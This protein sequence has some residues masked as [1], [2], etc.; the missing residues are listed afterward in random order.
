MREQIKVTSVVGKRLDGDVAYL[1]LKQFQEGTHRRAAPTIGAAPRGIATRR[2]PAC[3]LDMRNNPG[4]LVD[5]AE[6]VADEF[7]DVG[8]DLL[9]AAPRRGG[10]RGQGARRAARSRR[11]R[12]WCS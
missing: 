5:E 8:D 2:S 7:L 9:D 1:R 12:W 4:G 10:R 3:V 11:C 6:G